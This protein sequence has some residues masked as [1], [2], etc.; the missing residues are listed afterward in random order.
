MDVIQIVKRN[1]IWFENEKKHMKMKKQENMKTENKK[2]GCMKWIDCK[3]MYKQFEQIKL[4]L[5]LK[6]KKKKKI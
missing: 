5:P 6:K 2:A 4:V 1:V 3:H